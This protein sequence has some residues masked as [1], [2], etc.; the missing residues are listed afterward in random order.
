MPSSNM[1]PSSYTSLLSSDFGFNFGAQINKFILADFFISLE[2]SYTRYLLFGYKGSSSYP[3]L[4][5]PSPRNF[6]LRY[7]LG[8]RF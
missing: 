5:R 1:A 8:Y 3:E 2:A 7:G 4:D 6:T